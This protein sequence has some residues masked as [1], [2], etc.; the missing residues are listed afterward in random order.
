MTTLR[1]A[2]RNSPLARWQAE[3]V[4]ARLLSV[5]AELDIELVGVTTEGDR[6]LDAPL[7]NFGG[8]GLFIKEL[9]Q[10]LLAGSADI[11]V[12]SMKDVTVTLPPGL[13]IA[14]VLERE[15]PR[16][17]LVANEWETIAALPPGA[18]VGTASLRRQAQLKAQRRDLE[19]VNVRGNVDTRLAKLD[20]G[21]YDALILALAGV[22]RLGVADRVRTL[23]APETMLPAIGQGAIGVE[24]RAADRAVHDLLLTL[25][26]APT[27]LCIRT[28]RAMNTRLNGGCHAPI[29]GYAQLNDQTLQMRGLVGSLDGSKTVTARASGSIADP[30]ALGAEVADDLLANGAANI[31]KQ[32]GVG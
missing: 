8:K 20:A 2:T 30:E 5:H 9:E 7:G 31:L 14:V 6:R 13:E 25:D 29:A 3:F 21:D 24:C 4:R 27:H 17:A 11:A 23:L 28:E 1:I 12:H 10:Q 16:D 18:R 22:K 32:A 19:I 15:D 26:H